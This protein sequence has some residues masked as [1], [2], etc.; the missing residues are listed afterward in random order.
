VSRLTFN[1]NDRKCVAGR[2]AGQGCTEYRDVDWKRTVY[3]R[4]MVKH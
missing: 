4:G 3:R 1:I 2:A